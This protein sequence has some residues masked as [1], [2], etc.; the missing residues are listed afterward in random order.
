MFSESK[1]LWQSRT[2]WVNMVALVF[3]M[4]A[5]LKVALPADL[6][7][8]AAVT[9]IMGV[10]GAVNIVLRLLTDRPIG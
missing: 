5:S 4:L 10:L 9:A 7:Q 3:A 1:A 8:E 6:T 2:F